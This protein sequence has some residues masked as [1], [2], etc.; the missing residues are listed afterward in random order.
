MQISIIILN[1]KVPYHLLQCIASVKRSISSLSAEIIV[2]DNHSE[3]ESCQL[4]SHYFPEVKLIVNPNNDG[5]SKGNNLG[6]AQA[7]GE[8][9]CLLNPDTAVGEHTFSNLL[10]F[11]NKHP[12]FGAI[13]SQL[14]DGR[15][16]FLP[17]SKRNTPT[18]A[19]AIKKL[20]GNSKTYYSPLAKDKNGT[21]EILAGAFMLMRKDRYIE[22]G[23]LDEDYFMYGEDI[24]LSYKFLKAGYQNYYVG[25]E[26]ILHYKGESTAKDLTYR[27]RFYGAMMIFYQKH[28][29][30]NKRTRWFVKKGL[31]LAR[32][33]HSFL[34]KKAET[35]PKPVRYICIDREESDLTEK[36]TSLFN[37]KVT[38]LTL[39]QLRKEKPQKSLIVFNSE[40]VSYEDIF[41]AMKELEIHHNIFRIK[42][43]YLDFIIGSDDSVTQGK[44]IKFNTFGIYK[45]NQTNS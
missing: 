41:S 5:F 8:Y 9:I 39:S 37:Q 16:A 20:L 1:Y 29:E 34:N 3:D 7:N 24:D 2:V 13:G 40:H 27:K 19:I 33:S 4:V 15:G 22:I 42:P 38:R 18:P 23:G 26:T 32:F 6:I 44:I 11:A 28:F 31:H 30:K 43:P 35:L 21:I 10:K 36:L 12:N 17:E 25:Q 45:T 14:I